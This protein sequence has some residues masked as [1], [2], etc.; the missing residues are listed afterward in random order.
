MSSLRGRPDL[1][2]APGWCVIKYMLSQMMI[3]IGR[4]LCGWMG[5]CMSW[6][7]TEQRAPGV[8]QKCLGHWFL[9]YRPL[10]I[11]FND[12]RLMYLMGRFYEAV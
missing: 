9:I 10:H 2:L 5:G 1:S 4:W 3:R 12:M 7:L 11:D 8:G 6:V